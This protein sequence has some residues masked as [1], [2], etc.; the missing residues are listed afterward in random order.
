MPASGEGRP[1]TEFSV[2]D[3]LVGVVLLEPA[4]W[5]LLSEDDATMLRDTVAGG[6]SEP[7][8][9]AVDR[10]A[11]EGEPL[12]MAALRGELDE[13]SLQWAST[14]VAWAE[15]QA[16][17]GR[18]IEAS[19]VDESVREA[20]AGL[21]RQMLGRQSSQDVDPFERIRARKEQLAR[22]QHDPGRIARPS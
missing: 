3:K 6:P 22:F 12:T 20:V 8:A 10:L 16:G 9:A 4:A 1:S 13:E 5:G 2:G 19:A 15:R 18:G 14:L 17:G 11:A 21:L 7:V